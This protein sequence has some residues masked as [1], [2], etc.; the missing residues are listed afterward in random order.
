MMHNLTF[1]DYISYYLGQYESLL[2]ERLSDRCGGCTDAGG[3]P[4]PSSG[5][6]GGG[7]SGGGD[8]LYFTGGANGATNSYF[9]TTEGL[10]RSTEVMSILAS[11]TLSYGV[12]LHASVT[13]GVFGYLGGGQGSSV[14]TRT[15]VDK[16][17]FATD[18]TTAAGFS[19]VSDTIAGMGVQSTTTGFFVGGYPPGL[20]NSSPTTK[21][22]FATETAST[23]SLLLTDTTNVEF[24]QDF[25]F[26]SGNVS[27]LTKGYIASGRLYATRYQPNTDILAFSTETITNSAGAGLSTARSDSASAGNADFGFFIG[28]E[29][30]SGNDE[31]APLSVSD[32]ITYATDTNAVNGATAL[33][34]N[35]MNIVGTGTVDYGYFAGGYYGSIM[36]AY[37]NT[38][39]RIQY[40]TDTRS[41]PA[42]ASLTGAARSSIEG[43]GPSFY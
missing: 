39:E 14:A 13:D 23:S 41:T 29:N 37:K 25:V 33:S 12:W 40:A 7:G 30:S 1:S 26:E 24:D 16:I 31:S 15:H 8:N 38:T 21:V 2:S 36:A 11:A 18:T 4:P 6:G 9:S 17:T 32:K 3:S 35:T 43:T 10:N 27:S 42:S 28:G 5:G 34:N 19:L 22:I 20:E